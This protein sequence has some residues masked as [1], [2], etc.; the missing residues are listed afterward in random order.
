[1][2]MFDGI[3][4]AV[5]SPVA[6]IAS[7]LLGAAGSYLGT[8][9][10]NQANLD[11]ANAANQ[12]SQANQTQNQK[13]LEGQRSTQYQT[14]V[15]DMKAAGLNPMLAY[16]QGGAGTPS[17]AAAPVV[18]AAPRQNVLGNAVTTAQHGL[19]SLNALAQ[20]EQ[21]KAQTNLIDE[22]ANLAR[23]QYFNTLD[24]NP[25]I[26]GKAGH[27]LA[28]LEL[29]NATARLSGAQTALAKQEYTIRKP[30]ET[31]SGTTW[32]SISPYLKDV[33]S[34]ASVFNRFK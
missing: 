1:M 24:E 18:Q 3:L 2:G 34:A 19:Q 5:T 31:K 21:T 28:D 20:A 14:A 16:T 4:S 12:Q 7:S 25:Y 30:E 9:S 33:T 11:I 26:R 27:Q 23:A 10:A 8:Q 22:Q 17:S 15:S 32:G 6:S 29:K 13:W